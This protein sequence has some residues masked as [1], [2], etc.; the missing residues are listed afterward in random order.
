MV[1]NDFPGRIMGGEFKFIGR[2]VWLFIWWFN[3]TNR[4]KKVLVD[5]C[6]PIFRFMAPHSFC[7]KSRND[8]FDIVHRWLLLC[9][10][11]P[12]NTSLRE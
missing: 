11:A 1:K 9:R 3:V 7:S 6:A 8:V 2:L 12:C 10:D 5:N 4:A